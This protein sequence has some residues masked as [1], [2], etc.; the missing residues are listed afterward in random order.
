MLCVV[1]PIDRISVTHEIAHG[2]IYRKL[3]LRTQ[4]SNDPADQ[5][6]DQGRALWEHFADFVALLKKQYDSNGTSSFLIGETLFKPSTLGCRAVRDA[7]NAGSAWHYVGNDGQPRHDTSQIPTKAFILCCQRIG[8][9]TAGKIGSN[10]RLREQG[11]PDAQESQ[12]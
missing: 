5:S 10:R 6:T 11:G 9:K 3:N 2:I 12:H 4:N 7:L 8:Y 1:L